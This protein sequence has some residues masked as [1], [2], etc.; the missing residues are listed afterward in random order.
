MSQ[1]AIYCTDTNRII[2]FVRDGETDEAALDRLK[3]D[4][5]YPVPLLVLPIAEVAQRYED[6]FK[7]PPVEIT[8]ERWNEM[9]GILPPVGWKH[10]E[11]DSESFKISE[12]TAG[13]ITAI[14]VRIG[15]RY[16]EMS[17]RISM[18][19]AEC[20]THVRAKFFSD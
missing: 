15:K 7:S 20:V 14:F 3:S 4:Y 5:G 9:L 8:E 12:L 1:R 6:G 19:H 13:R 17:D 18:P 11:P 16:F 2:D 10:G